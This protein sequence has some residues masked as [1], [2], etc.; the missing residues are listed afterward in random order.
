MTTISLEQARQDLGKLIERAQA[1]EQI[2]IE[3]GTGAVQ[4]KPMPRT[5]VQAPAP[6]AL[7][8]RGRGIL[9]G[10]IKVSDEDLFGPLPDDELKLWNGEGEAS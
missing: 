9:K 3:G 2:V 4:L 7:S 10:M 5:T 8:R 6:H 1:G